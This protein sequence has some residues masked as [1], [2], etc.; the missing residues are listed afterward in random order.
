M[1]TPRLGFVCALLCGLLAGTIAIRAQS[2]ITPPVPGPE[3]PIPY[4]H[5][6]HVSRGLDCRMCHVKPDDGKLM[7]F[8]APATGRGCPQP[9]AA[10][11][12]AIQKLASFA[13][14]G[15]PIPWVRMYQMPDYVYWK[16]G[17]H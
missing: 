1:T 2:P 5:K 15:Q 14:S 3:Q 16:H 11:R 8:P 6:T 10:A 7:K 12:P 13:A 17:T 4:S 9:T